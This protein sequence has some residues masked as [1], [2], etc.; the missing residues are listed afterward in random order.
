MGGGCG[1]GAGRAPLAP[2]RRMPV[3]AE[4]AESRVGPGEAGVL[5]ARGQAPRSHSSESPLLTL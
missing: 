5:R 4:E 1:H 3:V 2:G